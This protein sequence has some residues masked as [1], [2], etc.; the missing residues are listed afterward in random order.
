MKF[1]FKEI[2]GWIPVL[3]KNFYVEVPKYQN[4]GSFSISVFTEVIKL[5]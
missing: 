4:V 3:S 1:I 2:M 5:K